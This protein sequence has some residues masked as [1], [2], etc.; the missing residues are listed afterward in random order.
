VYDILKDNSLCYEDRLARISAAFGADAGIKNDNAWCELLC[1]LEYLHEEHTE[2]FMLYT[3]DAE[4]L[5]WQ[6]PILANALAYF[7]YRHC[8]DAANEADFAASLGLALFLE[9]LLASLIASG[10]DAL[11]AARIIS[12]EIEYSED[13]T[14]TLKSVFFEVTA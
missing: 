4:V 6:Q 9:R 1:R 13:N 14:D 12:E 3:G 2:L 8:S 11:D 7:V 10:H 5:P